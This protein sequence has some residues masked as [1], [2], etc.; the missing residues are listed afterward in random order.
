MNPLNQSTWKLTRDGEGQSMQSMHSPY[1]SRIAST[2]SETL[3][4]VSP[5]DIG[6]CAAAI[7]VY[8]SWHCYS[9]TAALQLVPHTCNVYFGFLWLPLQI[10]PIICEDKLHSA[11]PILGFLQVLAHRLQDVCLIGTSM[12]VLWIVKRSTMHA[13]QCEQKY[14]CVCEMY[15]FWPEMIQNN[16]LA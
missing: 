4:A 8:S 13:L 1:I 16:S 5:A 2:G 9:N 11:W 10:F 15:L 7:I 6:Y 12:Q 14:G 3:W